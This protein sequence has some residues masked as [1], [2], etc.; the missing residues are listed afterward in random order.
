MLPNM[1]FMC[2]MCTVLVTV[3]YV[4][5]YVQCMYVSTYEGMISY[6]ITYIDEAVVVFVGLVWRALH[7]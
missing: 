1:N 4:C 5:I 6:T 7:E 3:L 2:C